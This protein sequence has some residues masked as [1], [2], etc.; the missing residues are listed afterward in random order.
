MVDTVTFAL[1]APAATVTLVG[2]VATADK[3][4]HFL[5]RCRELSQAWNIGAFAPGILSYLGY[6]CVLSGRLTDGLLL[7]EQGIERSE[8][9]G[10]FREYVGN[11]A[12]LSEAYGLAN[13]GADAIRLASQALDFSRDH[14][15]E[16]YRAWALRA[17]GEIAS[18]RDPPDTEKAE[19]S[20]RQAMVL[21][22]ELGMRPI[23]AHCHLGL[24][25]LYARTGKP[26]QAR[27]HLTTATTMYR[28]MDMRFWLDQTEAEVSRL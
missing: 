27:E 3:A 21:A 24:G 12:H 6:A 5:D 16:P 11:L 17:L 10:A 26:E 4:I 15:R 28:E 23:V 13:R 22:D 14:K 2:T 20:Y 1:V 9:L 8:S 19:A 18:H 7:L 25:K